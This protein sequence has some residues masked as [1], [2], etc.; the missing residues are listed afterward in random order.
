[1]SQFPS[2][3]LQVVVQLDT[4]FL[5]NHRGSELEHILL[6]ELLVSSGGASGPF[7]FS[8]PV[9]E[10]EGL[11]PRSYTELPSSGE[12]LDGYSLWH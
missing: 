2:A 8:A 3:P 9:Y 7:V 6:A 5:F 12:R 11:P 4:R 10:I 1:M